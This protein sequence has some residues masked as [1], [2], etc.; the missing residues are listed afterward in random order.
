MP[1]IKKRMV[2]VNIYNPVGGLDLESDSALIEPTK[3][4]KCKDVVFRSSYI[5]KL[6]G[7]SVFG[8]TST[9]LTG[10]LLSL[11]SF[12][13][14]GST[15]IIAHTTSRMYAYDEAT[16]AFVSLASSYTA[17]QGNVVKGDVM[18]GYYIYCNGK[19]RVQKYDGT[20]VTDLTYNAVAKRIL[21]FGSRCILF[22]V[23]LS[24]T[25]YPRR[26]S[27][28]RVGYPE[29]F[30]FVSGD[31][32]GFIDLDEREV[33]D[34]ITAELL[35]GKVY[36]YGTKGMVEMSL[37]GVSTNPFLFTAYVTNFYILGINNV[38]VLEE[39]HIVITRNDIVSFTGTYYMGV[40]QAQSLLPTG[41]RLE[42]FN[43][44][45]ALYLSRAFVVR[46]LGNQEL[47][48]FFPSG[49]EANCNKYYRYNLKTK[50]WSKGDRGYM[51]ATTYA[52]AD[53]P[54]IKDMTEPIS[55]YTISYDSLVAT[56]HPAA[57]LLGDVGG[58]VYQ[59]GGSNTYKGVASD[60]WWDTKDILTDSE[61]YKRNAA[62]YM[63][64]GIE[65]KGNSIDLY[66]SV[67]GGI[68]YNFLTTITLS[69]TW[70]RYNYD[71]EKTAVQMRFQIR[72]P[73]EESFDLK[74]LGTSYLPLSQ[75]G[76]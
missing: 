8:G 11:E 9:P 69:S 29:S 15:E 28:S 1:E 62:C 22:N 26:V 38:Y 46:D 3:T 76:V 53:Y 48:F 70:N 21:Q 41:I 7:D 60:G 65:A 44:I 50:V 49:Q 30:P 75:S 56:T 24:S 59:D 32:S 55:S 36:I 6:P 73:R 54:Q 31:G 14:N 35:R 10:D 51:C 5:S 64:V 18:F 66:Y 47:L 74:W 19:D 52:K 63:R 37:T 43:A 39:S 40:L 13:L 23:T 33:G 67:D 25:N 27:W 17:N 42:L 20:T 16:D 4:P 61:G 12:P 68:I 72:N 45:N 58:T 57:L 34:I 71:F 2:D